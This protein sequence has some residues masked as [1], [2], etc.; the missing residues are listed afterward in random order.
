MVGVMRDCSKLCSNGVQ[1]ASSIS[2]STAATASILPPVEWYYDE[3][4]CAEWVEGHS[5]LE[6]LLTRYQSKV[7]GK[8][9]T[10]EESEI[11]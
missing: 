8:Q 4:Q 9:K 10:Q 2:L 5:L 3:C 6:D 1:S 7:V 11:K